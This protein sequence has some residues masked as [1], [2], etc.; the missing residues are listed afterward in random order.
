MWFLASDLRR[1]LIRASS[2]A[3]D[4]FMR[5]QSFIGIF[6]VMVASLGVASAEE[7]S[8]EDRVRAY[9]LENPEVIV[10]AL[11]ILSER[12]VR[13]AM[14]ARVA[15]FPEL[16][17]DTA[18]LGEGDPA[19]PIRV[20]E[21]FDYRCVPCKE[22]HPGLVAFVEE[23]PE[24]RIEMRHLPILT[25]G[26]ERAARFALATE[27]TYGTSE[28][29]AV[30]DRLWQMRGPLNMAGFQRIADDL[31]LDFERIEQ[32]MDNEAISARIDFNR[33]VAIALEVLGTPAF[34]TRD[35]VTFGSTDIAA[36][37]ANWLSR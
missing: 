6:G 1:I 16:F 37:S 29:R 2:M 13:A 26:S 27:A 18:R 24:V 21:F 12:E 32:A 9:L 11:R 34:V 25:P 5:F 20:V 28:Y 19:A 36:L 3:T 35:S 30:H 33:D 17:S 31:G 15:E 8:F 23:H 22:V 7:A 10:E 4:S 14:T